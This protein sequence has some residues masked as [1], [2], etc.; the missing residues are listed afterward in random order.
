MDS[1][2]KPEN[3]S[4]EFDFYALR[5]WCGVLQAGMAKIILNQQEYISKLSGKMSS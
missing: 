3:D 1:P 4:V 5:F 2:G